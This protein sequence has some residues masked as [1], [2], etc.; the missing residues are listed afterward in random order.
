[1]I[2]SAQHKQF[3][4]IS[5]T[6][7]I[8]EEVHWNHRDRPV[9]RT[10][11]ENYQ[12]QAIEAMGGV[13]ILLPASQMGNDR[14][15]S[16]RLDTDLVDMWEERSPKRQRTCTIETPLR[17]PVASIAHIINGPDSPPSFEWENT[18]QPPSPVWKMARSPS[19]LQDNTPHT[20]QDDSIPTSDA[21]STPNSST[22]LLRA[23][24]C[25][26]CGTKS[27]PAWR[28]GGTTS[29]GK[30]RILCNACGLRYRRGRK[31]GPQT[32]QLKGVIYLPNKESH[33]ITGSQSYWIPQVL[34]WWRV[35]QATS[36]I[37]ARNTLIIGALCLFRSR[38]ATSLKILTSPGTL[39]LL[40]YHL[41]LE[42]TRSTPRHNNPS[43]IRRAAGKTLS[44]IDIICPRTG[45]AISPRS[46]LPASARKPAANFAK[47]R[48]L[49]IQVEPV[50]PK[51]F[52]TDTSI[53]TP[54]SN[55][56]RQLE[57]L[58]TYDSIMSPIPLSEDSRHTF[59][60]IGSAKVAQNRELLLRNG[61]THILDCAGDLQ[62]GASPPWRSSFVYKSL[63]ITDRPSEDITLH[64]REVIPFLED[65]QASS[66]RV[67][68]H[69]AKG[70]SRSAAVVISFVMYRSRMS[71][72]D[73]LALVQRS[74]PICDPNAG[75]SMCLLEWERSLPEA[76][77][78]PSSRPSSRG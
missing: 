31:S 48:G 39:V 54:T 61:I 69:C 21:S 32:P 5:L 35:Q 27:T 2:N 44:N 55:S 77:M 33:P 26:S 4:G 38:H 20:T 3:R 52:A 37:E 13:K 74:R 53:G 68:V 34:Y 72:T 7:S 65:A 25:M 28:N 49:T 67:L 56:C 78:R 17:N 62:S 12:R 43:R 19:P 36:G 73:A 29:E 42:R 60:Y 47:R 8:H 23:P 66:G 46:Y 64:F 6:V 41:Y 11:T 40:E 10:A 1:M 58:N 18:Q 22:L 45:R 16:I 70:I 71:F 63:P 51:R 9:K 50:H 76:P 75:F 30:K 57:N 14:L 15:P 24:S 59:L